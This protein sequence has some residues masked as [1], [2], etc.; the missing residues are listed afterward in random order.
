MVL[1]LDSCLA[2]FG[3]VR[4]NR[5]GVWVGFQM[6]LKLKGARTY[7]SCEEGGCC[8]GGVSVC[9]IVKAVHVHELYEHSSSEDAEGVE[10]WGKELGKMCRPRREKGVWKYEGEIGRGCLPRREGGGVEI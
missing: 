10:I 4:P 1:G 9:E 5:D 6:R 2:L 8:R 3:V 7:V